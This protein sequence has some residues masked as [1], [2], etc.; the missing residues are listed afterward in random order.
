MK[1]SAMWGVTD[2]H[3][4]GAFPANLSRPRLEWNSIPCTWTAAEDSTIYS[5]PW[6]AGGLL[7]AADWRWSVSWSVRLTKQCSWWKTSSLTSKPPPCRSLNLTVL[8]ET[9]WSK[10]RNS[11][12][13]IPKAPTVDSIEHFRAGCRLQGK[14][15][16]L[17]SSPCV[18][19]F[20]AASTS[21]PG[22]P[23]NGDG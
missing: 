9:G 19:D 13:E 14:K 12:R 3:G 5:W 6:L 16:R 4:C 17:P 23:R 11:D 1:Q 21:G 20:H 8:S 7:G 18:M 15:D 22:E 10:F 2:Q